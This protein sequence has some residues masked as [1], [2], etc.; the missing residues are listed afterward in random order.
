[1]E[2]EM[3]LNLPR[4]LNAFSPE[5]ETAPWMSTG[6]QD[7]GFIS[8]QSKGF[9]TLVFH[10]HY[11]IQQGLGMDPEPAAG[12][13]PLKKAQPAPQIP[14]SCVCALWAAPLWL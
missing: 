1:M 6:A 5:S 8:Q 13:P 7:S 9:L 12:L 11:I 4:G 10:E 2:G 14:K 3:C